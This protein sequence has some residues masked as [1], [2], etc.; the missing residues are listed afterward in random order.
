M[1]SPEVLG[2][3]TYTSIFYQKLQM[4][5]SLLKLKITHSELQK[6]F[7][8]VFQKRLFLRLPVDLTLEQAIT[9][10]DTS[11]KAKCNTEFYFCPPK[12]N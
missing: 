6:T 10:A 5:S 1:N 8:N 9:A 11:E 2:L 12:M 7:K 4:F 3:G